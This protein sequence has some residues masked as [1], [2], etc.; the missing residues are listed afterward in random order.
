MAR[1]ICGGRSLVLFF[2]VSLRA[3][4]AQNLKIQRS[5]AEDG[6]A[7]VRWGTKIRADRAQSQL[8]LW[9]RLG[10]NFSWKCCCFM[11]KGEL[12]I[13]HDDLSFSF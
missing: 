8:V 12:A 1:Y 5:Q 4:Q 3:R 11:F 13:P 6:I 2:E 10:R 9:V 7:V